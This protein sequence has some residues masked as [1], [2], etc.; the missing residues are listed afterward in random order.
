MRNYKLIL[1]L[2]ALSGFVYLE[3]SRAQQAQEES[4]M[5]AD[6]KP[7]ITNQVFIAHDKNKDGVLSMN[8]FFDARLQTN[9][10]YK[11]TGQIFPSNRVEL[12]NEFQKRNK[13]RDWGLS[14]EEYE[15]SLEPPIKTNKV[16]QVIPLIDP[17]TGRR[18]FIIP[19]KTTIED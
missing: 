4:A 9:S 15:M 18:Y 1:S 16:Q 3:N 17:R 5:N 11:R 13:N 12:Q 10:Y 14:P 19:Q 8:E 7:T 2:L 6:A